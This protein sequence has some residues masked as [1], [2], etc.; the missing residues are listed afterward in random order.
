MNQV[1][2][3]FV[4]TA[5]V[6]A[7][8]LALAANA[9]DRE[10]DVPVARGKRIVYVC[11]AS[12]SMAT[13]FDSI[14]IELR[15]SIDSLMPIESFDIIFFQEQGFRAADDKALVPAVPDGKRRAYAFMDDMHPKG[16][17]NPIPALELAFKLEP[18]VIY[19]L[20]VGDFTGPGNDRVVKFCQEKNKAGKTKINTIALVAKDAREKPED[21][22]FVKM[23]QTI[24]ASTVGGKFRIVTYNAAGKIDFDASE[25]SCTFIG[26][27]DKG[28]MLNIFDSLRVEIF[29]SV[30]GLKP[31]QS[32]NVV[33]FESDGFRAVDGK[34][35]LAVTPENKRRL[36]DFLDRVYVKGETNPK[37]GLE[38][39]FK[40]EVDVIY[41]L[42]DGD[43]NGPG[44]EAIVK[45][46]KENTKA[47]KPRINTLAWI[48]KDLKA[49]RDDL[50]FVK[51]MKAIA[52]NSGGKFTIVNEDDLDR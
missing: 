25:R 12:G 6:L 45:L 32:F 47:G 10:G 16:E 40:L 39:A 36:R 19:L 33:F 2:H 23:L 21:M 24:A 44:N 20:T 9:A 18:D 38:F 28:S 48:D 31:E 49:K 29:K 46:C 41:L 34:A 50:E 11:N 35:M 43:F 30:D 37:P 27:A 13:V 5:A 8:G 26:V 52:K 4:V 17:A 7:A 51:A 14:R 42:T 3:N 1:R 22:E 15:K